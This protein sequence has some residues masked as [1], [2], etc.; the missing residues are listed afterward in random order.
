[1]GHIKVYNLTQNCHDV[2]K[3]L[4][5]ALSIGF[6][7]RKNVVSETSGLMKYFPVFSKK[8]PSFSKCLYNILETLPRNLNDRQSSEMTVHPH[9]FSHNT[10]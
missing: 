2:H 9:N 7:I 6:D 3:L 5:L 10:E 4:L 1:M 8:T